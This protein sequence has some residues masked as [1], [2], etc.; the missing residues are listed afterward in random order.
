MKR[1]DLKVPYQEK[2]HAKSLG[3]KWDST[4]K[5]WYVP[6]GISVDPFSK[7][8]P[9]E[10]YNIKA[11]KFYLARSTYSCW[12]CNKD[13]FVFSIAV[14]PTALFLEY[15]EG[16]E[17]EEWIPNI[18]NNPTFVSYLS[19]MTINVEN[20]IK[21]LAP[22]YHSDFSKTVNTTYWMNHCE[23]CGMKQGDFGLHQ[24]VD[25]PFFPISE[26][27]AELLEFL[28]INEPIQC[29]GDGY[30]NYSSN[31]DELFEMFNLTD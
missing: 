4:N 22:R 9:K 12:S 15:D 23:H 19:A 28:E 3:A 7:W 27:Q 8:I 30:G 24:E 10:N 26:S 25:S 18:H 2:D 5:V 20:T 21:K 13:T 17:T 16:E 14:P 29:N 11:D 31:M 6:D 1:T